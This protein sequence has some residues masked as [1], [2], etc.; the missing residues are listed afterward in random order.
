MELAALSGMEL[1]G[2]GDGHLDRGE[3][4]VERLGLDVADAG[5]DEAGMA[6]RDRDGL[7]EVAEIVG[8]RLDEHRRF[9]ARAV[10]RDLLPERIPRPQPQLGERFRGRL[11]VAVL[12]GVLDVEEHLGGRSQ[13]TGDRSPWSPAMARERGEGTTRTLG[14]SPRRHAVLAADVP[15]VSCL[16]SRFIGGC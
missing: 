10:P 16:P 8:V 1:A 6:E 7:D 3:H 5:D 4:I 15:P 2:L 12:R 13:E 11:G 14:A 9:D